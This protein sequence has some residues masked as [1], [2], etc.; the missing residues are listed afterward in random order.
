MAE[1]PGPE[2]KPIDLDAKKIQ[3]NRTF[4]FVE[5]ERLRFGGHGDMDSKWSY[6]YEDGSLSI[7]RGSGACWARLTL[8]D[9]TNGVEVCEAWVSPSAFARSGCTSIG[10][11]LGNILDI[12]LHDSGR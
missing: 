2:H 12:I 7:Y 8:R 5:G 1:K 3:F 10:E 6:F 9:C 4:S 11:Y